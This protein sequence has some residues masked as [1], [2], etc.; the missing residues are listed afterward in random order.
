RTIQ[1]RPAIVR[2]PDTG[3][4]LFF[5]QVLL[6]H[7]SSLDPASRETLCAEFSQAQ[8]PRSVY[9]GARS[10]IPDAAIAHVGACLDAASRAFAWQ[11]GDV[12]LVDNMR[13]AHSR[14][15]YKGQRSILVAM[16][17]MLTSR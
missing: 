7:V 4:P 17:D 13:M 6:H 9:F 1:Q 3:E 12:L 2:H 16:G 11:A 14:N 8:L 5:N 10:P 15:P